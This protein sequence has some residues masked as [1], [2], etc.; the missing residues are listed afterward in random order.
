VE[1]PRDCQIDAGRPI[2]SLPLPVALTSTAP[3]SAALAIPGTPD[4]ICLSGRQRLGEPSSPSTQ[5]SRASPDS[6][7]VQP[8]VHVDTRTAAIAWFLSLE[9]LGGNP[10]RITQ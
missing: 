9:I 5:N 8:P 3:L 6:S 10:T 1:Q 4:R 7:V 2:I